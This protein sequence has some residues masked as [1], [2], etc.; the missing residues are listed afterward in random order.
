MATPESTHPTPATPSQPTATPQTTVYLIPNGQ[1]VPQ[2]N[3][4][5][6]NT[7]GVLSDS[8]ED[9]Y[10]LTPH[11]K[12]TFDDT[13][14]NSD[15]TKGFSFMKSVNENIYRWTHFAIYAS[16]SLIISPVMSVVWGITFAFL[17][18]FIIWFAQ[19]STKA[20]FV[21]FRISSMMMNA[22]VRLICDPIY[23][24]MSLVFSGIS[25][26]LQMAD[27]EVSVN[28]M[29]TTSQQVHNI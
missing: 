24:S 11:V 20:V 22:V 6:V 3:A 12:V 8:S 14:K 23:R 19:P 1:P 21:I 15:T 13:F 27:S 9:I 17:N 28:L 7:E 16:V 26:R 25:A 5:I 18:F 4:P 10:E 2:A 29:K